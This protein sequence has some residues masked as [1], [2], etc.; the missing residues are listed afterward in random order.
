MKKLFTLLFISILFT[1]ASFAQS[2]KTFVKSLNPTANSVAI[3]LEGEVAVNEWSETF[4]RITTTV[5]VT[6]FNEDI[7]K[8]LVSVGRYSMETANNDGVMMISMPKLAT[9]VTIKGQVL[10]EVLTY[11]VFVPKGMT[12]DVVSENVAADGVN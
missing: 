8:R 6:N 4:I 11:E 5:E 9:K 3:D 1:Q 2:Q 10:N 7:L 12:V